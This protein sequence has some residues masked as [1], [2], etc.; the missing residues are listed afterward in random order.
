M[1]NLMP[2][3]NAVDFDDLQNRFGYENAYAILRTLEQ[4]EGVVEERVSRLSFESRLQN[5]FKLMQENM[6]LQT[7]H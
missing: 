5:V 6:R 2:T 3:L 1:R 7:R 4:F